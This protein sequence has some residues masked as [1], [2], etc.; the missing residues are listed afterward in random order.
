MENFGILHFIIAVIMYEICG[1]KV[2]FMVNCL[3]NFV[4]Y[5]LYSYNALLDKISN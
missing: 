4:S 1:I 2:K 3:L 5:L